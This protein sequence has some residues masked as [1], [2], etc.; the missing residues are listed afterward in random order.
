MLTNRTIEDIVR[1]YR[2]GEGLKQIARELQISRN[3]VRRYVRMQG[4]PPPRREGRPSELAGYDALLAD[5]FRRHDG[6]ATAVWRELEAV[7]GIR[8]SVRTVQRATER[9]RAGL[10]GD[11]RSGSSWHLEWCDDEELERRSSGR[12]ASSD[13]GPTSRA[14]SRSRSSS[15]NQATGRNERK[16][17]ARDRSPAS[18]ASASFGWIVERGPTHFAASLLS[19]TRD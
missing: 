12:P 18:A 16:A 13:R 7:H 10:S 19:W 3:T 15:P 8:V 4:A 9:H 2:A 1:R 17:A 6:N 14:R 11:P 5:A